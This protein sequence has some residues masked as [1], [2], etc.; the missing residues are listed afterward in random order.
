MGEAESDRIS[1]LPESLTHHI[2]SFLPIKR[3]ASTTILSKRWNN[4]WLS[5]PVL[6]FTEW[7]SP[8]T[9]TTT[10]EDR[11]EEEEEADSDT[12]VSEQEYRVIKDSPPVDLSETNRFMHFL[13]KVLFLDNLAH[14]KKLCLKTDSKYFDQDRVKKWI[15]SIVMHDVEELILS[16]KCSGPGVVPLELFNCESLT[17]LDLQFENKQ[18]IDQSPL[19]PISFQRLKILRLSFIEFKDERLAV[20]VFSNCPVLEDLHMSKVSWK[21]LDVL[22]FALPCLKFFGIAFCGRKCIENVKV[23][24]DTPNL[25][26][27]M[28]FDFLPE[29]FIVDSFPCLV[30]A[31]IR[32]NFSE[33]YT[34]SRY[35]SLHKFVEKVSHVKHLMVSHTYFYPKILDDSS[36]L[37][38]SFHMFRNLVSF[39]VDI[40]YYGQIKSLF[41]TILQFSPN[42]TSL[43]FRQLFAYDKVGEDALSLNTVPRCLLLCLKFI[44]FRN[45]NGHPGEIE[46]VKLF[47]ENAKV[48]QLITFESSSRRLEYMNKKKPTSEEVEDANHKILEQLLPF[49]WASARC[50]VTFSSP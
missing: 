2:L 20:Q 14:I 8:P 38:R 4:L 13:D 34:K 24:F 28:W 25:L 45:F 18:V 9:A 23:K 3:A 48:L 30:E 43:V 16:I 22:C 37:P 39:E 29:E 41:D 26:S 33:G 31:G 17:V 12:D 27:L 5:L 21:G 7:R 47:L 40:I 11:N 44:E 32:Y 46:V 19:S 50:M 36:L 49:S 42:L 6:D 1:E 35:E 15:I 10:L